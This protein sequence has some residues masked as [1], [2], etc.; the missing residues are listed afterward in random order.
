MSW[1]QWVLAGA[2]G[3]GGVLV[4]LGC[5]HLWQDH[6]NLHALVALVQQSQQQQARPIAQPKP[7][8]PPQ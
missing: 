7:P 5:V 3:F 2:V 8:Q 4:G 6:A 1:K